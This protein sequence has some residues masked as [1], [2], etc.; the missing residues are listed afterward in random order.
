MTSAIITSTARFDETAP[1]YLDEDGD[2]TSVGA[3]A[4]DEH[5]E[6]I[7]AALQVW[8]AEHGHTVD[9]T[10]HARIT[11]PDGRTITAGGPDNLAESP[12]EWV[13]AA[14]EAVRS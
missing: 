1:G 3:A 10:D 2:L 6:H 14:T 5:L 8:A 4:L 11:C 12:A 13:A 7:D 9:F